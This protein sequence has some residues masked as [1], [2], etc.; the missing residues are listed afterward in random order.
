MSCVQITQKLG[1]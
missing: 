1:H